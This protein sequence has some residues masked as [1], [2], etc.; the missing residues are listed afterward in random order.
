MS[1][2]KNIDKAVLPDGSNKKVGQMPEILSKETMAPMPM[3]PV[4]ETFE[5]H[6]DRMP[7]WKTD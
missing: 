4:P 6:I 2:E 3:F 5:S 7:E 1:D